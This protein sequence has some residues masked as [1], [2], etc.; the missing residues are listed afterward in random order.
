MYVRSCIRVVVEAGHDLTQLLNGKQST[1]MHDAA[2]HGATGVVRYLVEEVPDMGRRLAL[3]TDNL[4]F[5]PL[6][7]VTLILTASGF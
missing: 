6:H 5:V 3:F 4:R 7:L 1:A 2:F